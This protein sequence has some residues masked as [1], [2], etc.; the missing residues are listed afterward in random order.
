MIIE[1]E[2]RW[3]TDTPNVNL[4]MFDKKKKNF[5]LNAT[6]QLSNT[7][8]SND[9]FPKIQ[10]IYGVLKKGPFP[11]VVYSNFLENG[12]FCLAILLERAGISYQSI[13]GST[14]PQKI[15]HIVDKY[16]KGDY[17]VL[18][19][20]SAGSESLD[21]KC[22]RQVHIMEPHWNESRITQV[23]GSAIRYRSHDQLPKKHR[24]VDIYRWISVFPHQ[25]LNESADQH[26]IGLSKRKNEMSIH[27]EDIIRR[28]SI[29]I[30]WNGSERQGVKKKTS[31]TQTGGG[32]YPRNRFNYLQ[33]CSKV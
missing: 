2:I 7:I 16:N 3:I 25:I 33:L 10:Q 19:I 1:K 22:T 26:L 18:L 4:D 30:N 23:I 15:N 28:S 17:Q 12:I 9:T 5:F 29:E 27:Y 13:T 11:A 14:S 31:L 24:H 8:D 21:L 20:S 6:R 32:T